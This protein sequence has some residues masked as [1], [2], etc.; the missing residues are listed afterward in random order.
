MFFGGTN[1]GFMSGAN[2]EPNM[3]YAP[4]TTS[5]DYDAFVTE[6]ADVRSTKFKPAQRVIR[7]FWSALDNV[8]MVNASLS[9]LPPSPY[10]SAYAGTV[11]FTESASIYDVLD[12]VTDKKVVS[13]LPLTMEQLGFGY[14][15]VMYRYKVDHSITPSSN[16]RV[17]QM[18]GVK[19]F[20][21]V[22]ADG[23]LVRTV[24]RNKPFEPDGQTSRRIHIPI[25]TSQLDI[26]IENQGRINYGQ[27]IHDRKGILGNIT[28]DGKV[29]QG[30]L[31]LAMS[32]PQD[33]PLLPDVYGNQTISNLRR[34][35]AGV[36]AHP[37]L[38][39]RSSPPTFFRGEMSI[40]PGSM[41]QF[42]GEYP[43][44]Y[45]RVFGRGVLWV[46]GFNLGRFHTGASGPQRS[47]FVP[48]AMLR[49]GRN[50]FLVL[51]MNMHLTRDPPKLQLFDKPDFGPAA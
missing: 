36:N 45:C 2:I 50:E 38:A 30:F 12:I 8:D 23:K 44:T 48:G 27:Y 16:T 31:N 6:Y 4:T 40:N 1:F 19:D 14:G 32:F 5:Y 3:T 11:P 34:R 17:L 10:M 39:T 46:N 18:G 29:I 51:H 21:Y 13:T 49:E 35:I 37:P 7:Q 41:E 26:I 47:L 43:G 25:D 15:F 42:G 28:L 22:L 9:E 24:D 33:H 20:A